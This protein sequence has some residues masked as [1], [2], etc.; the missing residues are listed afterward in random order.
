MSDTK[1]KIVR[2]KFR[3]QPSEHIS[4]TPELPYYERNARWINP[5]LAAFILATVPAML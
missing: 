4:A 2:F 5:L 1:N 3:R